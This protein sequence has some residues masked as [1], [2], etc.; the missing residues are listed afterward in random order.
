MAETNRNGLEV[1]PY[2]TCRCPKPC[3]FHGSY[4]A[5][6]H[7]KKPETRKILYSPGFGAGWTTWNGDSK[8]LVE[9]LLTY[10]PIINFLEKGGKFTHNETVVDYDNKNKPIY[11]GVHPIL[12]KLHQECLKKFDALIYMGGADDLEV[13]EVIGRVHIDEYDG[14][15]SVEVE[16]QQHDETYWL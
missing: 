1:P 16:G 13:K 2:K 10:K 14:N 6:E 8:E 7:V 4:C 5:D 11:K 9:Y 3:R 15:E 12:K